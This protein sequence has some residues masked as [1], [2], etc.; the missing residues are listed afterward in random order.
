MIPLRN[1]ETEVT[2]EME[3]AA[4]EL[5]CEYDN[6]WDSPRDLVRAIFIAMNRVRAAEDQ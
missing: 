2:P 3:S 6:G 1:D 5:L 4:I